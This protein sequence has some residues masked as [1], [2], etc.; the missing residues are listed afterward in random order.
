MSIKSL[1]SFVLQ[2]QPLNNEEQDA[3]VSVLTSR[4]LVKRE[5]L[6]SAGDVTR[7]IV[8]FTNGYFRFYH[9][10]TKGEEVTSD[11]YFPPNLVT[12]YTSM[13]NKA[14]SKV[15]VQAME[16]MEVLAIS[17][18][19]IERLYNRYPA[20]ERLGR[21][22]AEQVA[23]AYEEHL[24]RLLSSTSTERYEELLRIRP[25]YVSQIPVQYLASYL[26]ITRETLSRIRRKVKDVD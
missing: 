2:F 5:H 7:E 25:A 23:I 14:A 18:A 20:I 4:R 16:N 8:F 17:V 10:T 11:F 21:K 19:D 6:Y 3:I 22:I 1:L 24:F 9:F 15:Y 26:G 13:V 12:S